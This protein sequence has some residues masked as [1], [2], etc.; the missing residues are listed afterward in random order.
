[1]RLPSCFG[2]ELTPTC[3]IGGR[4]REQYYWDS[5]WIVEGLLES[6]LYDIVN[7]TLHNFMDELEHIGFIPNGGRIYYL[8]RSQ[9]P[10]FVQVCP[11]LHPAPFSTADPAHQMLARY[12][13]A[14]NETTILERAL[15]LA[16]VCTN[17]ILSL[18]AVH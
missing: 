9:P 17:P 14:T 3:G 7:A 18:Q 13:E 10:L 6:E 8:N 11:I 2:S 1:M 15:P 12:V 16:E 5:F 4:F